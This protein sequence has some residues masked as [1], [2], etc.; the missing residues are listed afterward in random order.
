ANTPL[1]I[2]EVAATLLYA[3][4]GSFTRAFQAWSQHSPSDWRA[5]RGRRSA[6]APLSR[7]RSGQRF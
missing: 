5:K 2:S 3:S 6:T 7:H 4:I 1:P